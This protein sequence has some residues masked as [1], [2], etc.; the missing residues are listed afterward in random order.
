MVMAKHFIG[1][2][3]V[4]LL[5][6]HQMTDLD[7][8]RQLGTQKKQVSV[9]CEG[10]Q[11]PNLATTIRIAEIFH[12]SLNWLINGHEFNGKMREAVK[13]EVINMPDHDE[14]ERILERTLDQ[15][16]EENEKREAE[17]CENMHLN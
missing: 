7:L 4:Q 11:N 10:I 12:V 17:E 5:A 15:T 3:L 13:R 2:Q 14:L 16:L 6:E 9:W 1:E 8:A